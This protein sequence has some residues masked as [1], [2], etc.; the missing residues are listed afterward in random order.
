MVI[1]MSTKQRL[2]LNHPKTNPTTV[3]FFVYF[4][5]C[6]PTKGLVTLLAL[7]RF[8]TRVYSFM[9][10]H[11][12]WLDKALSQCLHLSGFSP[13]CFLSCS[14][15]F[16]AW[17][18]ALLHFLHLKG[19][20]PVCILSCAFRLP[21]WLKALL[22]CLHLKG[23]S[24]LCVLSWLFRCPAWLNA[25]TQWLQLNGFLPLLFFHVLSDFLTG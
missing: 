8:F 6:P 11:I 20:S 9:L 7:E 1:I 15:R 22:H 23:F 3:S 18:K 10:S 25:L 19:F 5:R 2:G 12:S 14:F 16:P 24:P 13:L 21:D 17:L 4:K